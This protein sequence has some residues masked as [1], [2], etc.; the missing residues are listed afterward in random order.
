MVVCIVTAL[1]K[2]LHDEG[3][4]DQSRSKCGQ[5]RFSRSVTSRRELFRRSSK[6]CAELRVEIPNEDAN[7][8]QTKVGQNYGRVHLA[9]DKPT[10]TAL[11]RVKERRA[12]RC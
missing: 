6:C 3:L 2:T 5:T 11:L 7:K 10:A 1:A 4:T 8:Q 9:P 12:M